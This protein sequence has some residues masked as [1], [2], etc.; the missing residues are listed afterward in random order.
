MS[1]S[2]L[3]KIKIMKNC[4]TRLISMHVFRRCLGPKKTKKNINYTFKWI[5]IKMNKLSLLR[6][7]VWFI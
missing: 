6:A 5:S 3:H 7:Y 4:H 2:I 1:P